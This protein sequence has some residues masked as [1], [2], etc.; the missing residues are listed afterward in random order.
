MRRA[1]RIDAN[2]TAIVA[3]LRKIGCSV[4]ITSSVGNGFPDLCVSFG[5]ITLLME[6]KDG[7]K[8]KSA[9]KL[10]EDQIK[11]HIGWR[12][13]IELV[14]SVDEAL[15]AVNSRVTT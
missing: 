7:D 9:Q 14:T 1:A 8:P 4:A 3:A 13:R 5:G 12:G 11:F 6:V 15:K 2:Q 10:T